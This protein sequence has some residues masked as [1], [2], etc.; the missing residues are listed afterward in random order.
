MSTQVGIWSREGL[1]SRNAALELRVG[2]TPLSHGSPMR[3]TDANSNPFCG[4]TSSDSPK[5]HYTTIIWYHAIRVLKILFYRR[6]RHR[7]KSDLSFSMF[8]SPEAL[9]KH[10]YEYSQFS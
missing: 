4:E 10:A 6:G 5:T 3:L 8:F 1:N 7:P 2:N 9:S